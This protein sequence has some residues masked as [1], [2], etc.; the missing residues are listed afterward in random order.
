MSILEN[1]SVFLEKI[2]LST[3]FSWD[4]KGVV[5]DAAP[6]S[7]FEI[8]QYGKELG[9]HSYICLLDKEG[10]EIN[11]EHFK[12]WATN[13][14]TVLPSSDAFKA[15]IFFKSLSISYE[16]EQYIANDLLTELSLDQRRGLRAEFIQKIDNIVLPYGISSTEPKD[17]E[18]WDHGHRIW[19]YVD[20]FHPAI[21]IMAMLFSRGDVGALWQAITEFPPAW[22]SAF[23]AHPSR[24]DNLLQQ[25]A[26]VISSNLKEKHQKARMAYLIIHIPDQYLVTLPQKLISQLVSE[27]WQEIGRYVFRRVYSGVATYQI[28]LSFGGLQIATDNY[29][30][31]STPSTFSGFEWPK[32]W[33]AYAGYILKYPEAN[34]LLA[35]H[36]GK[37]IFQA[38]SEALYYDW[39]DMRINASFFSAYGSFLKIYELQHPKNQLTITFA[40]NAILA[41]SSEVWPKWMDW[42]KKFLFS[43]RPHFYSNGVVYSLRK[44]GTEFLLLP[45]SVIN[46]PDVDEQASD[47]LR[48]LLALV[49]DNFLYPFLKVIEL[50]EDIWNPRRIFTTKNLNHADLFLLNANL[51]KIRNSNHV[52]VQAAFNDFIS[53]WREWAKVEWTWLTDAELTEGM[54]SAQKIQ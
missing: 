13:M 43:L 12:V 54:A 45:S 37:K 24:I 19:E 53:C 36:E 1:L 26:E 4:I 50:E 22:F 9:P 35:S 29:L 6:D 49:Q 20:D 18:A 25:D 46:N 28:N 30:K 38:L 8:K 40:M 10:T 16:I 7:G 21:S 39:R 15:L 32:D 33:Q 23:V 11:F 51:Q 14:M 41:S 44:L 52:Q 48:Q 31:A 47:R 3:E 5:G 34:E 2:L 27:F 42:F 17:L